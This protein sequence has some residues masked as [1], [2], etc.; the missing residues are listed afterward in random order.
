MNKLKYKA[1]FESV[2]AK[3]QLS[4]DGMDLL[5][6]LKLV[7]LA[8]PTASGRNSIINRLCS[9]GDYRLIV[10]DTTRSP[11]INDG[12]LEE[13]GVNYWF[14]T[15]EDMLEDLRRGEFLEAEIIH[16][17]QVSG[18]SLREL[19]KAVKEDKVAVTDMEI[20]GF[21][22][23]MSLKPDVTAI[24]ILPPSF[25][26]WLNRLHTRGDMPEAE[27]RNRL[28]TGIRIFNEVLTNLKVKIIINDHL[29]RAVHEVE[30]LVKGC[31]TTG[32]STKIK[33]A[34]SL[35]EQTTRYLD[36]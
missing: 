23:V 34:R 5:S 1:Q 6:K 32:Q 35:L 11:R 17:Q 18:I 36:S 14:R 12:R 16:N 24:L 26:E 29:D 20:G 21:K 7:I 31:K 2:L 30:T 25:S 10:S 4:S 13:N 27:I 33:L 15:E 22:K 8:G 28:Q 9:S 3:Y 19:K